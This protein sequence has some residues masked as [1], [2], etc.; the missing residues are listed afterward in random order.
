MFKCAV[1]TSDSIEMLAKTGS[2]LHTN[3]MLILEQGKILFGSH[4]GSSLYQIYTN[5][6]MPQCSRTS[7]IV[8]FMVLPSCWNATINMTEKEMH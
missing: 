3:K 1:K 6:K 2:S 8:H 5:M 7:R 4:I